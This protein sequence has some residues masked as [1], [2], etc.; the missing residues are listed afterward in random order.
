MMFQDVLIYF[1]GYRTLFL[2][3]NSMQGIL[4]LRVPLKIFSTGSLSLRVALLPILSS[5]G[6]KGECIL[7]FY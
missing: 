1:G 6:Y 2:I 4:L 7:D 3:L 5:F